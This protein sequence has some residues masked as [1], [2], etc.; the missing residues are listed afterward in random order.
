MTI[1]ELLKHLRSAPHQN[2]RVY[3]APFDCVPT[4]VDSWR[5]VYAEPALGWQPAGYSGHVATYPTVASLTKE[6]EE[7]VSGRLHEGWKGG[8]FAYHENQ[9]LHIDNPGDCTYT[10]ISHVIVDDYQ[11]TI[12][13]HKTDYNA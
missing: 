12:V 11:V 13:V 4:K 10:D 3:F 7:A 5:G 8:E 9:Q 2:A 6:L 1:G